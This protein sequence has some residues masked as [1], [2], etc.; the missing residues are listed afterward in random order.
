M[1]RPASLDTVSGSIPF[2]REA[3]TVLPGPPASSSNV[4]EQ[5]LSDF[6]ENLLF[7]E[8]VGD[9]HPEGGGDYVLNEVLFVRL[10][11]LQLPL[12]GEV[13]LK[14]LVT[15]IHQNRIHPWIEEWGSCPQALHI[16]HWVEDEED[17]E[18]KAAQ[19]G[20]I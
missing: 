8:N 15:N 19:R 7:V 6:P 12:E 17:E 1:S 11:I 18:G 13:A 2:S 3:A 16:H 4:S 14:H 20:D 5:V 10:L 9:E